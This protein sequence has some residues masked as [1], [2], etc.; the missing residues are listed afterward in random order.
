MLKT[1][2]NYIHRPTCKM[3]EKVLSHRIRNY[4]H[5]LWFFLLSFTIFLIFWNN[6]THTQTHTDTDTDTHTH[7]HT[8]IYICIYIYLLKWVCQR[9]D[10]FFFR[11]LFIAFDLT[12]MYVSS[13]MLSSENMYGTRPCQ[14]DLNSLVFAVWMVYRS[15]WVFLKVTPLF[16]GV[17][18]P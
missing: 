10:L 11:I 5:N 14:W 16:F 2:E 6:Q 17:C 3:Q 4:S 18:L 7:I 13:L 15:W 12:Y 9:R 1:E 8:H